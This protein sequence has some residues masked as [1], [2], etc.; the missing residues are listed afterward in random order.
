MPKR[1]EHA[2]VRIRRLP[3]T[4]A[5]SEPSL[6]IGRESGPFDLAQS[7]H[8]GSAAVQLRKYS[9]LRPTFEAGFSPNS[10]VTMFRLSLYHEVTGH[11][12]DKSRSSIHGISS[13]DVSVVSTEY[14]RVWPYLRSVANRSCHLLRMAFG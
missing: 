12:G 11:R 14:L 4:P 9:L 6:R 1:F 13:C 3:L 10:P 2:D 7:G 5:L 8:R